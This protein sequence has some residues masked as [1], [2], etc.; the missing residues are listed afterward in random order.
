MNVITN[1][2]VFQY[3]SLSY[4]C[5]CVGQMREFCSTDSDERL[6]IHDLLVIAAVALHALSLGNENV[7]G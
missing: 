3:A 6:E 1:E 5:A 7:A 4:G 2:F